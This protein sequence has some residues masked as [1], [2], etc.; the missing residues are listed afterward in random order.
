MI[1]VTLLAIIHRDLK[2]MSD[3]GG[4][5]TFEFAASEEAEAVKLL[6]LRGCVLR[7]TVEGA[8]AQS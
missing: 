4:R 3:G 1:P 7:V 6:T 8:E 2:F 5:V